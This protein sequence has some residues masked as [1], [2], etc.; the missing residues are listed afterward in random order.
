MTHPVYCGRCG[1][2]LA[3]DNTTGRCT[4]CQAASRDRVAYAPDVPPEFWHHPAIQAAFAARHMG[5]LIRAY[6][7]HP[8]HGRHP[9]PQDVVAGWVSLTQTQLSRI[10]TGPPLHHLDRLIQWARVL[11]IP[12]LYL[13]FALP[14]DPSDGTPASRPDPPHAPAVRD[15]TAVML[16]PAAA[17]SVEPASV[18]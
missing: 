5:Q 4:P 7:R 8:Y 11:H 9:I 3:R 12:A 6:R 17:G 16:A 14:E 15:L 18:P 10:E 13:W 1:A 2:R